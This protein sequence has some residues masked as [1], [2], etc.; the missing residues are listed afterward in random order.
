[1]ALFGSVRSFLQKIN[2]G[3]WRSDEDRAAAMSALVSDATVG[4][5]DVVPLLWVADATVRHRAAE[6]FASRADPR[7]VA[8]LVAEMP[9]Q[10]AAARAFAQRLV[11]RLPA[12][13]V[14]PALEAGLRDANIARQRAAWD[15]VTELPEELRRGLLRKALRDANL[16]GP[17]RVAAVQRLVS[18][19]GVPSL[20]ADLVALAGDADERLR[21]R[22]VEALGTL[23]DPPPAVV[24][25]LFARF[26]RDG[27]AVRA[28]AGRAL[29]AVARRSPREVHARLHALLGD[30]DEAV[31]RSAVAMLV[32][33][34]DADAVVT[35]ILLRAR[36]MPGWARSGLL[37]T[38]RAAGD[39]VLQAAVKLLEHPDEAVRSEALQVCEQSSD[40]RLLAPLVRLLGDADGWVRLTACEA[41]GRLKDERAVGPLVDALQD[42][43]ARWA[44][45]DALGAVGGE[46]ALRALVE[47]VNDPR[48]EVRV[49]VIRAC[50]RSDDPRLVRL[51]ERVMETDEDDGVR[52]RATELFRQRA[53]AAGRAHFATPSERIESPLDRL[54]TLARELGASD[55]HVSVGEPPYLR[56]AGAIERLDAPALDAA[57]CEGLLAAIV[58]PARRR[59]LDEVGEVDLCHAVPG[60]GRYRA[61][62]FRQRR[63]V[64]AVFRCI[65]NLPPTF[66]ELR[67]P[68]HLASLVELRRGLVLVTGPAGSGKS[69]TLAALVNLVNETRS[70]H[71][72]TLEDPI[73]F[74]HPAKAALI[75]QR[76][77]GQHTYGFSRALRAA[78]REDPDV[79]VVG[80][81]RDLDTLR[82]ALSAA[83]TGH[84]VIATMP[85]TSA[86]GTLDRLVDAFPADEQA[87][88][89]TGLAESLRWVVSQSLVPRADGRGR[90]PVFEVLKVVTSVA[91]LIREGKHAQIAAVMQTSRAA[92]MRTVEQSL[93]ELVAAGL[94]APEY[95][96]ARSERREVSGA[97][98]GGAA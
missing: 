67:I 42:P 5:A 88:V 97:T 52:A 35:E 21:E 22:S 9:Q 25:V 69:T 36:S 82:M 91:A 65:P 85:T 64:C 38:L 3:Q 98:P 20:E 29:E 47:L 68:P 60:V 49:E 31:R 79:I 55:V 14:G 80:E 19:V 6:V 2:D 56:I 13:I 76:E 86:V 24:D 39:D 66:A 63:G 71:V 8:T 12:E 72:I 40:P 93:E 7:A 89:R 43:E 77:V 96:V 18:E 83:E 94:V 17:V 1:M 28:L 95:A 62:I 41:L 87:Q 16:P 73:E 53:G 23:D 54:L 61:N 27:S 4:A 26:A 75:N 90:L 45:I 34:A 57:T 50:A 92:G 46:S 30:A 37:A 58:D 15:A 11:G 48:P 44:A 78:L 81:M 70:A 84:L 51:F 33:G 74:V 10:H 59:R 32:A